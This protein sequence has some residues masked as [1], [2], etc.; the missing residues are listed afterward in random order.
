MKEEYIVYLDRSKQL[1][2]VYEDDTSRDQDFFGSDYSADWNHG[3][4]STG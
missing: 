4:G 3:N 2:F 1:I